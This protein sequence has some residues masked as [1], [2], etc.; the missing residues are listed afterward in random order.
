MCAAVVLT[1]GQTTTG[2]LTGNLV[3]PS[4]AAIAGADVSITEQG[5][6]TSL[7]TKTDESGRFAFTTLQP[8]NYTLDVKHQG[9]K[10]L[11]RENIALLANDD[12]SLTDIQGLPDQYRRIRTLRTRTILS[13]RRNICRA[14][15]FRGM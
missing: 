10:A 9:F 4:G 15:A 12:Y 3:D 14:G 13:F 1:F 6:Q 7:S 11:K 2:S 8:G 5:R